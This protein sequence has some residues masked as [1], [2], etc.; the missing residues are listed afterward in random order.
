MYR[1]TTGQGRVLRRGHELA[2][3]LRVIDHDLVVIK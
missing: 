1:V 3:V 2:S